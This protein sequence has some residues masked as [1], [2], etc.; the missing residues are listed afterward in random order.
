ME[1]LFSAAEGPLQP[2]FLLGLAPVLGGRLQHVR[3]AGMKVCC[4][5]LLGILFMIPLRRFLIEREHGK[6]PYPEGTACAEV[7]ASQ[8]TG[9][10]LVRRISGSVNSARLLKS[11]SS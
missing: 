8:P 6:L 11:S 9:A 3:D 1:L 10:R 2:A 7:L 5:G 4:G